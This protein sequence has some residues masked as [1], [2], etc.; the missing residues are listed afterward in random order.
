MVKEYTKIALL[1]LLILSGCATTNLPPVTKSTFATLEEDEKGLWRRSEEEQRI[2]N[3][4]G[5]IYKDEEL[6]NYLNEIA[7]KLTPPEVLNYIQ[8]KVKVIKNPYLNAFSYPN[9]VIYVHTGILARMDN[10]AQLAT[11]LGHEITHITHRHTVRT[12]RD[13]KNKTAFLATLQVSLAVF[14]NDIVRELVNILGAIGT[15]AAVSGYSQELETQA[16]VEGFKLMLSAGY[17]P[18]EAPKLFFHLKKELEDEQIKEPFFFGTHPRLQERIQNYNSFLTQLQ[19]PNATKNTEVFLQKTKNVILDNAF[20]DLKAG[21][22]NMA[23][24]GAEKY[25]S[26]K[27]DDARAYYLLGEIHR[28]RGEKDDPEKAKENYE[29]AIS[30]D[31]SFPDSYKGLGMI[32]YKQGEKFLAK[33][34][35]E[36]YLSVYP[37]APDKAYIEEYLKTLQ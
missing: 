15:I 20:L 3:R 33:K 30:L 11:L 12:F 14:N 25:L 21:R 36:L 2:I 8:F 22:F 34:Y 31:P 10:E 9:G 27:P 6:E 24:R 32:Y 13:I 19:Y 37:E 1:L 35:F 18:Y 4:S 5:L 23:K 16:D 7:R 26:I 17:D 29:R 28:Q